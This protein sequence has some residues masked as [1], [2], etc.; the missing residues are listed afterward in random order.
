LLGQRIDE[1]ELGELSVR[2]Y[3]GALYKGSAHRPQRLSIRR[4]MDF[5]GESLETYGRRPSS[6]RSSLDTAAYNDRGEAYD[7]P[8][9]LK[10]AVVL[11]MI[12]RAADVGYFMQNWETLIEWSGRLYAEQEMAHLINRGR[13]PTATWFDNQLRVIQEYVLPLATRLRDIGVFGN[14]NGSNFAC[15]V[16]L[17]MDQWLVDGFE[18]T[19]AFQLD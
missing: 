6:G 2:T 19:K 5:S 3:H 17:N 14:T 8:D 12:L 13:D 4:S 18:A 9:A 7:A 1:E 15:A 11:E 16:A 10:S